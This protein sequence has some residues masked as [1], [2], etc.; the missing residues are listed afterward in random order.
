MAIDVKKIEEKLHQ[1]S[2]GKV[3]TKKTN[4]WR[5]KTEHRVRIIP[6]EPQFLE[7]MIHYG[8]DPN[9]PVVCLSTVNKRCPIC[10]LRSKLWQNGDKETAGKLK[11]QL[12][13]AT[14]IVEV[15]LDDAARFSG[16]GSME[17]KW[18]SFSKKVYETIINIC[19]NPEYGDISDTEKGTDLDVVHKKAQ[20]KGE[21]DS[22][23]VSPR[24]KSTP[25]ATDAEQIKKIVEVIP[26]ISADFKI[27][28][29]DV[30]SKLVED[31]I[32]TMDFPTEES[33][34]E[35]VAEAVAPAPAAATA[36]ET[37]D[38]AFDEVSR[39]VNADD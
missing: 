22:T 38:S 5:P 36:T 30:L 25:L 31:W 28:E 19:K 10:Q 16:Q 21:F 12:R 18:W 8:I 27:L 3:F 2:T 32:K 9:G 4:Y 1:L 17:P 13:I 33:P 23:I 26:D 34:A 24:R 37:P 14:P 35:P 29:P 6:H 39:L 11:A 15:S 20:K 7:N